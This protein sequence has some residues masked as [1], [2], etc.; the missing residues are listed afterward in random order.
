MR[1]VMKFGGASIADGEKIKWVAELINRHRD[2]E[3]VVVTSSR[4]FVNWSS[5]CEASITGR[6]M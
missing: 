5:I 3:L 2:H 4:R 6:R 1:L